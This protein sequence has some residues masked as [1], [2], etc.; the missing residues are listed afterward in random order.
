MAKI[1]NRCM[2]CGRTSESSEESSIDGLN[3][4]DGYCARCLVEDPILRAQH[5]DGVLFGYVKK[6]LEKGI[7]WGEGE[8][9]TADPV[10]ISQY[11]KVF[12]KR[13]KRILGIEVDGETGGRNR[14]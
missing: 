4:S 3:I 8:C 7:D 14:K 13:A 9:P 12:L 1:I 10:G 11:E 6:E 2:V 5:N